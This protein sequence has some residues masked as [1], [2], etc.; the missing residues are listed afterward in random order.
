MTRARTMLAGS[1]MMLLTAV[2][3][4]A[5]P[6]RAECVSA[7]EDAQLL[8]IKGQLR[9][10]RQKL[11]VCSNEGCPKLV[12][13]DCG[14]WLDEVDH[15]MPTVVLGA[16][17]GA[18]GKDLVDVRVTL[19][20]EPLASKLDGKA[21]DVDV[22][23]HTFH[24]EAEG[25]PP[26]DETI[27]VREGEKNRALTVTLG[28][29]KPVVTP[30]AP[31]K[32]DATVMHDEILPTPAPSHGPSAATWVVG[33]VGVAAL[34]AAGVIG[35]FSLTRRN[36]LYNSC[37]VTGTCSPSSVNDVT[38]LYTV[39]YVAAGVGGALLVTGV[40]LFFAT[41]GSSPSNA[42][43]SLVPTADGAALRF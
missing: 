2:T 7:S 16:R 37:G 35:T 36:D 22:G 15:A 13:K 33:G 21:V 43:F 42:A 17:D 6:T 25:Q 41:R 27:V 10:A 34:I 24:F 8:K 28:E 23:Q 19:D 14:S 12:K 29:A 5:A 30:P 32:P 18:S 9:A 40:V 4:H 31:V 39:S 3:A 38:S 1:A 26:H 20:G 11:V